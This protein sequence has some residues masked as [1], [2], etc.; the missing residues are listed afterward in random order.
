MGRNLFIT[1]LGLFSVRYGN[2]LSRMVVKMIGHGICIHAFSEQAIRIWFI[3]IMKS[4][5]GVV[6]AASVK[7]L[8]GMKGFN[9]QDPKCFQSKCQKEM[10]IDRFEI[11]MLH[12]WYRIK[13]DLARCLAHHL[14]IYEGKLGFFVFSPSHTLLADRQRYDGF[15]PV[16]VGLKGF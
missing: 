13:S 12:R 8:V 10:K 2:D 11:L 15:F 1:L 14:C 16:W 4:F 5:G 3:A 6:E 7:F 9:D